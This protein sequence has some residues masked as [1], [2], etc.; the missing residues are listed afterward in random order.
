MTNLDSA[1]SEI[2]ALRDRLDAL[3]AEIARTFLGQRDVTELL[4]LSLLAGGHALLEGAPGLGKTTLVRSLAAS[5]ALTFRRVQFTPDLMP[6]DIIG[7]RILETDEHGGHSFAFEP[8]PVFT[9]VLLADEINRATPRTQSALLEAMQEQ[10]VTVQGETRKL[11]DPFLVIATQ[12]PLEM[13]GTYPLPEA[14]L[15]RFLVKINLELPPREELMRILGATTGAM[16]QEPEPIITRKELRRMRQLVREV[17]VSDDVVARV[18][19]IVHA[20]HPSSDLAPESVRSLVRYGASPRGGQALILM[21]KARALVSGRL[22]VTNADLDELAPACLRHRLILGY[23]ADAAGTTSD[24]LVE[25]VL[26]KV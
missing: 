6:A 23:E 8:G 2:D 14:Q 11:D 15:D 13:E 18:A 17:P 20:T 7:T 21:A 5:V 9:N 24:E 25:A 1:Q 26:A 22:H 10:Q 19:G 16:L 12:N 4:L 3:R